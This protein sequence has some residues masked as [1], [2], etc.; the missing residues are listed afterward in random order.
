MQLVPLDIH[1]AVR[2]SGGISRIE[3]LNKLSNG[4]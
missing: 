3:T 4:R 1:R 2:H